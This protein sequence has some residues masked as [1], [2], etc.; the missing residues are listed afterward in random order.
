MIAFGAFIGKAT[1]T[2][3]RGSAAGTES[4]LASHHGRPQTRRY[5]EHL[6]VTA[7]AAC[8]SGQQLIRDAAAH[9]GAVADGLLRAHLRDEPA[10]SLHRPQSE[11][12]LC[13]RVRR[14]APLTPEPQNW[15]EVAPVKP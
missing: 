13:R 12:V 11:P 14:A 10:A 3:V 2:Q 6:K 15:N 4:R 7:Y 1:P 9:A 5:H 8:S